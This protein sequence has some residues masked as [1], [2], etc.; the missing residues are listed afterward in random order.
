MAQKPI[1]WEIKLGILLVLISI[2]VYSVKLAVLQNPVVTINY[3]FNSLGFLP[4]NVL[5]VTI[6]LNS[7][8]S[9]RARREKLEKLSVVIGTFFSEVGTTLLTRFSDNDP[10]ID[11]I[12]GDLVV[13]NDWDAA[14][15]AEVDAKLRNYHYT[16]DIQAIDL[17]KLRDFL[18]KKRD[19]LL[20]M[21]E[22]PV[23]LEHESFTEVLRATFH[24]TE[25]L[26]RRTDLAQLPASDLEH[27]AGD[28]NR[29]Y[30]LLVH[31][32]L[33]YMAYMKRNYPYLFSLA[34]RTNPFDE[35]ATPVVQGP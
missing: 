11:A 29:V 10:G 4:I 2:A 34:M 12:K 18:K 13:N 21:L 9:V 3:I 27:L 6:V 14:E 26:E 32:W 7:L 31:Q 5:L 1:K 17:V 15:F 24:L 25:E 23:M 16:V 33:E 19:F 22:N 8:L 28:V 35:T 20:R 30:G